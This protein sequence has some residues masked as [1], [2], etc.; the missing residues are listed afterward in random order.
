MREKI[1]KKHK[2]F[3]ENFKRRGTYKSNTFQNIDE[4]QN[5]FVDFLDLNEDDLM[6]IP[7]YQDLILYGD[8]QNQEQGYSYQENS[9]GKIFKTIRTIIEEQ[10]IPQEEDEEDEETNK[11]LSTLTED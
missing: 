5:D 4:I 7:F 2:T 1:Q 10:E 9:N 8:T 3:M 11:S 6:E